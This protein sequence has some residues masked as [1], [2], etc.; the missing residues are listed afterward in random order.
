LAGIQGFGLGGAKLGGC[1][2]PAGFA[3]KEDAFLKPRGKTSLSVFRK[4]RAL[5]KKKG[6]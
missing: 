2:G 6:K 5:G 3:V 4:N 1:F